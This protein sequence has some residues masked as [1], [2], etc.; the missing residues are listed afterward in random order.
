[1]NIYGLTY[2]ELEDLFIDIGSKKLHGNQLF[3]LLYEKIISALGKHVIDPIEEFLT[4]CLAYERNYFF[5]IVIF[6]QKICKK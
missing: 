2:E 3:S 4:M 1:M 6:I 5:T